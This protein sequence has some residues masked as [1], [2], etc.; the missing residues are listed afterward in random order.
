MNI[1]IA[2]FKWKE[3][4]SRMEIEKALDIIRSVSKRVEGIQ[5]IYCGANTSKWGQGFT[6][7]VVVI[8][9]SQ[10]A[11]DAYRADQVHQEAAKLIESMELDGIG[12]DL[13][14]HQVI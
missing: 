8:G 1:H 5:S 4:A 9:E 2:I 14:D 12:V 11:I 13:D 3:T 10:S 6:D 7:A